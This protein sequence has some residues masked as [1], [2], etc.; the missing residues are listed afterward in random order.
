MEKDLLANIVQIQGQLKILHWQTTSYAEHKA[1]G[2][3]YESLSDKFDRIVEVYSGKYKRPKFD[4]VRQITLADYDNLKI[5]AFIESFED[6]MNNTFMAQQDSE[7]A[8]IKDEVIADIQKL[9]YLLSL[10]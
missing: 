2:E 8:N 7:L 9:K 6:F 1:F 3:T 5:D 10:K 4:G